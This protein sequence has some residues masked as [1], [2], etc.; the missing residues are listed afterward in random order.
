MKYISVQYILKIHE[1]LIIA[2]GGL[3]GNKGDITFEIFN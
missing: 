1:K 3:K 2:T